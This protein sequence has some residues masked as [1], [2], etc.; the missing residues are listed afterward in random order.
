MKLFGNAELGGAV[1][2]KY[3][4]DMDVND[5]SKQDKAHEK[6]FYAL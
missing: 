5:F 4:S 3:V 2:P 1:M 6:V